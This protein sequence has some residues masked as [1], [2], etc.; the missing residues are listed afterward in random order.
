M[1]VQK[2]KKGGMKPSFAHF[3]PHFANQKVKKN[4]VGCQNI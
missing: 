1:S 2:E 4:I 3:T